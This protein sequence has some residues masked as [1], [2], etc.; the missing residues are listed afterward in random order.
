MK[1]PVTDLEEP[2]R[3]P[4]QPH[5]RETY[6][7]FG[8]NEAL[9]R[10]STA[11]R[12]GKP[13]QGLLLTGEPGIGKATL[14]Y[15]IARYILRFGATPDGPADLHV[16]P[17]EMV[18]R[19]VEA[20][21]HPGLLVLRRPW[22]DKGKLRSELTVGEI[23]RLGEFFGMRSVSGGWRIALIDSADDMNPN[24]AN[25][26]LKNLEEPP[27]R[28]MLILVSHAPGRLLPTIRSRV[29]RLGLKPLQPALVSQ[30][31]EPMAPDLTH[32]QR[33]A[34][35][36]IADGSLGLA[37]RLAGEDGAELAHEVE[38]LL[39][40]GPVP[41]WQSIMKL[42]ERAGR[43]MDN[44]E[45]FGEFLGRALSRRIRSRAETG[46][47]DSRAVET[48]EQLNS[49]FA[50]GVGVNLAPQQTIITSAGM[51]AAAKRQRVI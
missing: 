31:L 17:E 21:A 45:R 6:D 2:D 10:V 15:R 8:Q 13:P 14:A 24:A 32:E 12:T 9:T 36:A 23:R 43:R 44:V 33:A 16:A 1:T 5:P 22:D 46:S 41:D 18:A 49:L 19:Q 27:P 47:G 34:V 40:S 42:A 7:L 35:T 50:R 11:I 38:T 39:A 3:I 25:A 37:L 20:Q 48:W 29:Q 30:M 28:S 51:I 26:L 4:G